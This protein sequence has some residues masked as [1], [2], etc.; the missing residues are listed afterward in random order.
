MS[1]VFLVIHWLLKSLTYTL[2]LGNS[3]NKKV[4]LKTDMTFTTIDT[5]NFYKSFQFKRESGGLIAII[6]W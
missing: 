3:K 2:S 4:Y 5:T 1:T 6:L